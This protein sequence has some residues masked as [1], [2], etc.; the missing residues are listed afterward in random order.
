MKSSALI[1]NLANSN[2]VLI[3]MV[4]CN[5][6]PLLQV[7][8]AEA[9][10]WA[11]RSRWFSPRLRSPT[12]PGEHQDWL[13]VISVLS[14]FVV[15]VKKQN[16]N[17]QTA[18]RPP[19]YI[20]TEEDENTLYKIVDRRLRIIIIFW[21]QWTLKAAICGK[22]AC[23]W[24][25]EQFIQQMQLWKQVTDVL[26]GMGQSFSSYICFLYATLSGSTASIFTVTL[27]ILSCTYQWSQI[28]LVSQSDY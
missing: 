26:S 8:V 18:L 7:W 27:M 20:Q 17:Q 14:C 25:S 11:G 2:V 4:S 16:K 10:V 9:T 24:C 3:P 13:Q 28:K 6:L 22:Q 19:V 1:N 23:L 21:Q 12:P 15:K 5:F